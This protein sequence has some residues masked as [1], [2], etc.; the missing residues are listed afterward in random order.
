MGATVTAETHMAV[1]RGHER[2]RGPVVRRLI[3]IGAVAGEYVKNV[4]LGGEVGWGE[5]GGWRQLP[6][7]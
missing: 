2:C 5:G 4:E 1:L 6:A 7:P 3:E